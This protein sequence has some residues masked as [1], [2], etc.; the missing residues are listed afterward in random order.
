MSELQE[1]LRTA[2]LRLFPLHSA[3]REKLKKVFFCLKNFPRVFSAFRREFLFHLDFPQEGETSTNGEVAGWAFSPKG[4]TYIGISVNKK[5]MKELCYGVERRDVLQ[6]FFPLVRTPYLGFCTQLR[7]EPDEEKTYHLDICCIDGEGKEHHFQRSFFLASPP[8]IPPAL[9]KALLHSPQETWM[10]QAMENL[11]LR[12]KVHFFVLPGRERKAKQEELRRTLLSVRKT[13]GFTKQGGEI[14]TSDN[15]EETLPA[16]LENKRNNYLLLL[17]E[18]DTLRKDALFSILLQLNETENKQEEYPSLFMGDTLFQG[19]IR[20]A[21]SF[22]PENVRSSPLLYKAMVVH[23]GFFR[24]AEGSTNSIEECIISLSAAWEEQKQSAS[25]HLFLHR[26]LLTARREPEKISPK[27]TKEETPSP[28]ITEHFSPVPDR[29]VPQFT[30]IHAEEIKKILVLKLDH[31]GDVILGIPAIQL[32]KRKYPHAKITVLCGQWAVSFLKKLTVIDTLIPFNY[33]HERSEKWKNPVNQAERRELIDKLKAEGFDML[34]DLRR[35]AGNGEIFSW[36]AAPYKVAFQ[37]EENRH[38]LTHPFH[39]PKQDEDRK[40]EAYKSHLTTQLCRLVSALPT[41]KG[42]D[43][44]TEI[45]FPDFGFDHKEELEKRYHTL[46]NS[47]RPLIGIHPGTGSSIR[48]W[49]LSSYAKLADMLIESHNATIVFFGVASE[50]EQVEAIL[51][52]MQHTSFAHSLVD[53]VPIPQF[54]SFTRYLTLFIGNLTGPSHIAGMMG[55]PTLT[56]FGGQFAPSECNPPGDDTLCIRLPLECAP[57]YL[58]SPE[59]CPY[60]LQ[61]LREIT[62]EDALRAVNRLLLIS[63]KRSP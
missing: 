5:K 14:I 26:P 30:G 33:F 52:K 3:G 20:K 41:Q 4:I 31:I 2:S 50:K 61:C 55:C 11:P 49:A 38:L 36:T 62:P 23:T 48:Q 59:Q 63:R 16:I 35:H 22:T 34:I 18:G 58:A 44:T 24:T 12:P 27:L 19:H 45:H 37:T 7:E 40:G 9:E 6:N 39:L 15:K 51:A 1:T 60:T 46:F 21:L 57:C 10:E 8:L 17:E 13:A 43:G 56:I 32:L 42:G 47:Q 53:E 25:P 54:M 29:N 28:V